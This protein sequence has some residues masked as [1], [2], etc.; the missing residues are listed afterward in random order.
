MTSLP[1]LRTR[2]STRCHSMGVSRARRRPCD[3]LGEVDAEV[4]GL[5]HRF[6]S[7][8]GATQRRPK[9]GEQLVHAERLRDVVVGAGV[10][11]G[12][13]VGLRIAGRQDE[14]RDRAPL[15]QPADDLDAVHPREA[16]VEDDDV[17]SVV[18]RQLQRRLAGG[19]Q[20]DLVAPGP[21][22]GRQRPEDG[23]FVV[24][25]QDPGAHWS[26]PVWAVGRLMTIVA[27]PP[28]VSS[29]SIVPP[30]ALTKPGRRPGRARPLPRRGGRPG[31]GTVGTPGP[32]RR[33][34]S[35]RPG[36]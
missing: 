23:R 36:R 2:I 7:G 25:G 8:G 29:I 17:G 9:P 16:E 33:A 21:Q 10:E 22:V 11:G 18:G 32:G 1:G 20:V 31:A 35:R 5:D 4:V 3:L 34:G 27:P 30:M 6:S 24:D 14:D 28:G 12:D 15:P 19:G 26:V 13:L